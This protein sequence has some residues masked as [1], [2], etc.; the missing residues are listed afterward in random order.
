M[1]AYRGPFQQA[2]QVKMRIFRLP[3]PRLYGNSRK[4]IHPLPNPKF[5]EEIENKYDTLAKKILILID[6]V[7]TLHMKYE[8]K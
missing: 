3:F 7:Y 6:N 5:Q 2:I 8:K 1:E 4:S